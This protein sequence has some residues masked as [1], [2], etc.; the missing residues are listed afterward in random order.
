MENQGNKSIIQ[1]NTTWKRTHTFI[2][3]LTKQTIDQKTN[4]LVLVIWAIVIYCSIFVL[5]FILFDVFCRCR[6]IY[7]PYQ[8]CGFIAPLSVYWRIAIM[9][10]SFFHEPYVCVC[11]CV[12]ACVD[13]LFCCK[14]D[15]KKTIDVRSNNS[16]HKMTAIL[17]AN[18]CKCSFLTFTS[19]AHFV[20]SY[21]TPST[22]NHNP[23]AITN[24]PSYLR[25]DC[26]HAY[27]RELSNTR[28]VHVSCCTCCMSISI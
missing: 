20:G 12:R 25:M 15:I 21:S 4:N 7:I 19:H 23:I 2:Q 11:A 8:G 9:G 24:H 1:G 3:R 22:P 5:G 18:A 28:T 6:R 26:P 10:E 17:F 13:V 14:I 27:I 16:N